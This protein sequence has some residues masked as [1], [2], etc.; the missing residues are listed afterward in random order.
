MRFYEDFDG[1]LV[2]PYALT[3]IVV[4]RRVESRRRIAWIIVRICWLPAL[5]IIFLAVGLWAEIDSR[6]VALGYAYSQLAREYNDAGMSL[7]AAY[8]A[9]YLKIS[10]GNDYHVSPVV[11]ERVRAN[12]AS[13]YWA[14][15]N[16]PR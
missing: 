8:D 3:P 7:S 6:R 1:Y 14:D 16:S 15:I 11:L 4:R 12:R 10:Y 5:I 13:K 9:A 2:N